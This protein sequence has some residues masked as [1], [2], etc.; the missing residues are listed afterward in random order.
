MPLHPAEHA[1][2]LRISAHE[3]KNFMKAYQRVCISEALA[4]EQRERPDSARP[5][6]SAKAALQFV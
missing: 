1:R 2:A 6:L 5:I 3:E 4:G